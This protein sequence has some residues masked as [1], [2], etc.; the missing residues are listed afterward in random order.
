MTEST[1]RLAL[2]IVLTLVWCL[3]AFKA[4]QRSR[5]RYKAALHDSDHTPDTGTL[6]LAVFY[7]SQ[8]GTAAA[9]AERTARSL[10]GYAAV[11]RPL[12]ATN[13]KQLQLF[14]TLLLILSTS[15]EGDPPD[16]AAPFLA[17]VYEGPP[18][19]L[20]NLR[21]GLLALGDTRYRN[22]CGFAVRIENWL[23]RCGARPLFPMVLVNQQ[24]TSALTHWSHLIEQH[25]QA[26]A[27]TFA[28]DNTPATRQWR[29]RE[30]TLSNPGSLG[31]PCHH[32]ILES[33]DQP[34]ARWRGGDIA[35]I[36]IAD[37]GI[38]RDYSIASLPDEG[39]IRLLVR[40]HLASDGT[41]GL[42]S[43]WLTHT[44][45]PGDTV[46][47]TLRSNPGFHAPDTDVPVIFIGNGTGLAGLRALI[48][49]RL[50]QGHTR[51]WLI[52]GERQRAHDQH[53]GNELAAW[54]RNG[55]LA[56]LDQAFS[57]DI[58]HDIQGHPMAYGPADNLAPPQTAS[59]SGAPA[60]PY[61]QHVLHI[62]RTEIR[63]W[64]REG[65][66]V[67]VCGSRTGMADAVDRTL[68]SIAGQALFDQLRRNGRYRQDVY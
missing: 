12:S 30:R 21:Y 16:M 15:G 39:V 44:L 14:K 40:E 41:P 65:A 56:H 34:T 46:T 61:V 36:A 9:L 8:T 7:A 60:G 33:L 26:D 42:G 31:K 58:A 27:T 11:A 13:P 1:L 59:C 47:I 54:E 4:W 43:H 19:D 68:K 48:R 67:Y 3:L 64:L 37:L 50:A 10:P 6:E 57:R 22:Y 63:R 32:L 49:E 52:Y 23:Q 24:Q 25:F 18:P 38:Q 35:S 28:A 66:W 20:S 53:Y 62:Q 45:Q 55:Y 2:A 5:Q 51:N 29:L 17:H